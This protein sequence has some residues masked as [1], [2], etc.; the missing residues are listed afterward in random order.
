MGVGDGYMTAGRARDAVRAY[1]RGLELDPANADL[2]GK[3]AAARAE[4]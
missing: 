3:L 4:A 2:P 1:Q